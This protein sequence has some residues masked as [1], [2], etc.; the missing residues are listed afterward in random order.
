MTVS[1]PMAMTRFTRCPPLGYS[2]T[3]SSSRCTGLLGV[4]ASPLR[5]HPPGSSK[6][7][8]SPRWTS[9]FQYE[10]FWTRILSLIWRVGSI[11]ADGM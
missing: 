5:S 8:M 7:T 9:S 3:T 4:V 6:T 11:E 10:T 2:P 1:P